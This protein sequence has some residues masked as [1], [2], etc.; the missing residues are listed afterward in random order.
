MDSF[1]PRQPN[2]K[3][4]RRSLLK[5]QIRQI[6]ASG[7]T[8]VF[9]NGCFDVLHI[10]QIRHL[11]DARALGDC[12]VVGINSDESVRALR[13]GAKPPVTELERAEVI[14]AFE[15]VD[16][17]AIFNELTADNLILEIKPQIYAK[18]AEYGPEKVPELH[19]V[20]S[21]GGRMEYVGRKE[22]H[23]SPCPV[24]PIIASPSQISEGNAS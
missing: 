17:V 13:G 9:T 8:V 12:L 14:A 11:R 4:L 22:D 19:T 16:Y 15:Y 23:Q 6:Q 5:A 20:L 24:A 7:K 10:G 2:E 18:R 1:R 21:Y 3:I